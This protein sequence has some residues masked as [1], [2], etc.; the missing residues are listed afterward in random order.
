MKRPKR[1]R[2]RTGSPLPAPGDGRQ[3]VPP[4][5]PLRSARALA[6]AVWT[7]RAFALTVLAGALAVF[8]ADLANPFFNDVGALLIAGALATVLTRDRWSRLA[9]LVATVLWGVSGFSPRGPVKAR[10]V[11]FGVDGATFDRID[12]LD[13]P[14]FERL[15]ADGTRATLTSMEPMFSP[16]LWTTIASGR[17]PAE[18]GIRGF[19]V[20]SSDCEVARF[21]D[22]AEDRGWSVGLYK[23][24]VDYPPRKV[25]GF[26]VP[27]WL[28]PGPET[29]PPELG[30]VKELELSKRMRRKQVAARHGTVALVGGLVRAGVR[31][32]TL[33]RAAAWSVEE[34]T[35]GAPPQR[36]NL[37]MQTLR[38]R[39]D[40]DVFIAQLHV[41]D[42]ELATFTY[43]AT[44]GLAHLYW[45]HPEVVDAAYRQA[46][47]I[48]GD[49]RAELG[50]D[51]RLFV[52]S[53]HGFKPMDGTGLAG[54]FAPL[55]ARLKERLA[56]V[57]DVDVAR[58]GHKLTV[59]LRDTTRQAEVVALLK[60]FTGASG[61]P[62]YLVED[63]G[64][65]SVGLTLA[66][67]QITAERLATE[68]VGGE[69]IARYVELTD[70]YTGTHEGRGVFYAVGPGVPTG[71]RLDPVAL[72][73]V[74]PT[75]LAAAG[76]PASTEMAGVARIFPEV[77]PRVDD[78]DGVIAKLQW[79]GGEQGQNEDALKALGYVE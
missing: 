74:A 50:P 51:A 12:A 14:N 36:A 57:A 30:Y 32:S 70:A 60:T 39:I 75:I 1:G 41:R 37:V 15:G 73:D 10:I 54:Q 62:F 3:A 28:A 56:P 13:L 7:G 4:P 35:V 21:W 33:A 6:M 52:V 47:A 19:H 59:G 22:I 72:I 27:S 65:G 40:R 5:R 38:G 25:A 9:L 11:V 77:T 63:L 16:L 8:A 61:A 45:D 66:D 55:T 53:D 43:Y 29:W 48:L 69:P 67:E 58:V 31:L 46:D 49:I 64:A 76:I 24:L 42:P 23:W 68:T 34:R 26:W 44:D 18:H 17:P 71:A 20:S 78:W 2:G 79:L